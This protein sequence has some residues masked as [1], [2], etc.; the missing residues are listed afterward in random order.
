VTLKPSKFKLSQ[1]KDIRRLK[2]DD[3]ANIYTQSNKGDSSQGT[4]VDSNYIQLSA[5]HL[6]NKMQLE[7]YLAP[8]K[9]EIINE[10]AKS[11]KE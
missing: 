11:R 6:F 8:L 7:D 10:F 4:I 1:N 3:N 5:S 9:T 2:S